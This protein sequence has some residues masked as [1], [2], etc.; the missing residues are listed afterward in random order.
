MCQRLSAG[1]FRGG[2][3]GV[4]PALYQRRSRTGSSPPLAVNLMGCGSRRA[5]VGPQHAWWRPLI[6][7]GQFACADA[8]AG[9]AAD[10]RQALIR[11]IVLSLRAQHEIF[12]T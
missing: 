1:P 5:A 3:A 12:R 2:T 11:R 7:A 4:E 9:A 10:Q 8:R 6:D